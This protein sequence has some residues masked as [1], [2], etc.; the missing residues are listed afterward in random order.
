MREAP[1]IAGVRAR[2]AIVP[3]A[4][5]IRT[6]SGT[7]PSAPLVL[8]DVATRGGPEG[9]AYLFGYTPVTL[10]PLVALVEELTPMLVGKPLAPQDRMRDMEGAFRLLGRQGLLG[11]A[12]SGLEMALWDA[13]GRLHG[14]GV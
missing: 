3:L 4:R 13:L 2:A 1:V 6:A 7:V 8:L 10:R 5:P 9:R 14:V 11:M 12:I